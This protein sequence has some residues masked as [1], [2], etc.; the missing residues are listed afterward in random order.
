MQGKRSIHCTICPAQYCLLK[1]ILL[2]SL[3]VLKE[4]LARGQGDSAGSKVFA[5]HAVDPI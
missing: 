3:I 5:L 2:G 1:I 4:Q